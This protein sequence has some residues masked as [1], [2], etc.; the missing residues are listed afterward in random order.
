MDFKNKTA[1][2]SVDVLLVGGGIMSATLGVLLHELEPEWTIE[3]TERLDEV[4]SESSN[5]W[6][7]AGTGH[8][9]LCEL[10]Y[11]PEAED[12]TINIEKA[13]S[14][15]EQFQISRQF[16]AH[17]VRQG[18]LTNP[19][20]FINRTPHMSFVWGE[21]NVN[22][23][24][25]RY[26]ALVRS[27]LFAGMKFST[28]HAEISKWAP[29][30]GEGLNPDEKVAA[31]WAPQGTDVD[32]G[33]ITRQY[34]RFLESSPRFQLNTGRT[35]TG[36]RRRKEGGW[37]V[38]CTNSHGGDKQIV[39]AKFVFLGAGGGALPLLQMSGIPEAR[40][41]AGFP[42]GGSFLVCENPDV[43]NKHNVKVYGKASTGAPPMSVPHLDRRV[44]DGKD[45]LLFGP[46]ATFSTKFLK[47]GSLWD[48]PSSIT[49][50][51]LVPMMQVG[52]HNFNL[53]EYLAGQLMLSEKDRMKALRAYFPQA[54]DEDW[55]LWQAGQRV[56]IIKKDPKNGG[57]L[58]LGTEI[59]A[60]EDRS[61]AAL[62]GASPGASTAAPIMLKL[63]DQVF[64]E[65]VSSAAWQA[66]LRDIVP[67]YGQSLQDSPDLIAS[68]WSETGKVLEL[69]DA[70][71]EDIRN[72]IDQ[73]LIS[74]EAELKTQ[75]A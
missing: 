28:D 44:I 58:K 53:V 62:L 18:V 26:E 49:R 52:V 35:V 40:E 45:M 43:V 1:D 34:I 69:L 2:R 67:S 70:P 66:K 39:D 7:N 42:V 23:L 24:R 14:I 13:L 61:I 12:G 33:E 22:F 54:R 6:N 10:N 15:N 75:A 56:Q 5:G 25:K 48:L 36:I 32:Y 38:V 30:M 31:T 72:F 73:F 60:C 17:Q 64:P 74:S 8:S 19:R 71:V 63:L 59:V 55:R 41:Y 21:K 50:R 11:T 9:A 57:Q 20:S 27:P 29:L 51:N 68:E 16:W 4:A 65:R 37:R 3:L 47:E 46:F